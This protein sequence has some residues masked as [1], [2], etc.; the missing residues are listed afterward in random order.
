MSE[1]LN[2][3]ETEDERFVRDEMNG[4]EK[5]EMIHRGYVEHMVMQRSSN[6]GETTKMTTVVA[7]DSATKRRYCKIFRRQKAAARRH[8]RVRLRVHYVL[9]GR[10]ARRSYLRRLWARMFQMGK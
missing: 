1:S 3:S 4:R 2:E 8:V 6:E 5:V 10:Y 9:G 7:D